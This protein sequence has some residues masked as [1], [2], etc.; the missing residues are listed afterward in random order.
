MNIDIIS[1]IIGGILWEL[2]SAYSHFVFKPRMR[3]FKANIQNG[4]IAPK[5]QQKKP[6]YQRSDIGFTAHLT[7][8]QEQS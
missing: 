8:Q 1:I 3:R 7:D 4:G 6:P 5:P 2:I